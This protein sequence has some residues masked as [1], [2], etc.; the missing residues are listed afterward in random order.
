MAKR[1]RNRKRGRRT[2]EGRPL[3]TVALTPFEGF[4][5]NLAR[6]SDSAV[7]R[8]KFVVT[9]SANN[10]PSQFLVVEPI[11]LGQRAIDLGTAFAR[12]RIKAL[13]LRFLA[14]TDGT[15]VVVGLVDDS[16]SEGDQPGS[17][18]AVSE[19]RCSAVSLSGSTVPSNVY[20]L[21]L[22]HKK[23]YYTQQGPSGSDQRLVVPATGSICALGT[24]ASIAIEIDYCLVFAGGYD[25]ASSVSVPRPVPVPPT[26]VGVATNSAR[27]SPRIFSNAFGR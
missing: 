22:D 21:P 9:P 4:E 3:T 27:P 24:I 25:P 18:S 6:T 16:F 10:T 12:Y 19:L 14:P 5:R 17:F 11:Y 26:E 8:G 1:S 20:Y 13:M 2:D 15:S 7:L 23:W